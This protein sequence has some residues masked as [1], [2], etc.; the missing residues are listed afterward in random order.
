MP[1]LKNTFY[2]LFLF[3]SCCNIGFAQSSLDELQ[4]L[5]KHSKGKVIYVDIW[6]SW[7]IPCRE[8]FPWMNNMQDKYSDL[9]IIS[10]NLDH[11]RSLT[12]EFLKD[13]PAKFPII[14][15]PKGK[16]AKHYKLIGMPSSYIYNKAGQLTSSHIGFNET[17]Q[18]KYELELQHLLSQ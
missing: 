3:I 2:S 18:K 7:C 1:M 6:A 9:K 13:V 8:S 5:L 14:Y 11:D 10:V 4:Q 12:K 17:K 16:I 15:D